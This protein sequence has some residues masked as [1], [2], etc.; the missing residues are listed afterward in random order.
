M[1]PPP[2]GQTWGP[3]DLKACPRKM[4]DKVFPKG[5]SLIASTFNVSSVFHFH[6]KLNPQSAL[7]CELNRR[8]KCVASRMKVCFV[9]RESQGR[10]RS[11]VCNVERSRQAQST[12]REV[13]AGRGAQAKL[14]GKSLRQQLDLSQVCLARILF[15]QLS[16]RIS[17]PRCCYPN[18]S[19][20]KRLP[21]PHLLSSHD[22]THS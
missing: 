10:R 4:H 1:P 16:T 9:R 20:K 22:P 3:T 18:F 21:Q 2:P 5:D 14:R 17:A 7:S 13:R 19:E 12:S 11:H 15:G 6:S 8:K